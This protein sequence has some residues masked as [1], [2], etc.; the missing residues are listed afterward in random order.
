MG[1][2]GGAGNKRERAKMLLGLKKR[3]IM[4]L[5]KAA[6]DG[7]KKKKKKKDTT[8]ATKADNSVPRSVPRVLLYVS[9]ERLGGGERVRV[10]GGRKCRAQRV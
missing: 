8:L 10:R 6:G 4:M 5:V 3:G 1:R 2:G 7:E 9:A